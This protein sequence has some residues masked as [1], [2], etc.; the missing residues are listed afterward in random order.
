MKKFFSFV[1]A[2]AIAVSASAAPKAGLT[3]TLCKEQ[4]NAEKVMTKAL[5]APAD[6][7]ATLT[8][9]TFY[10]VGGAFYAYTQSGWVDA[11]SYMPSVEVTV[12]GDQVSIAGLAYY[13]PEGAITG[14]MVDNVI[15]FASGQLVGTDEYGDEYLVGS[16]DGQTLSDIV[17]TY[18]PDAQT[19]VCNMYIIESE[20]DTAMSAYT[21]WA[22]AT[23]SANEPETPEAIIVPEGLQTALYKFDGHD[24]YYDSLIVKFVNVGFDAD[25]VY[26]QGM[27]DVI[28]DGWIKGVKETDGSYTF[29]AV[30]LGLYESLFGDYD[31]Y[32]QATSM[33]YDA[34]LDKFTCASFVTEAEGY[35]MDEFDN[36]TLSH[37]VEVAA[38]PADPAFDQFK[39][40]GA[41]YPYVSYNIPVVGTQG[42]ELNPEKLSY[43]FFVQKG[44]ES[45]PL[46]LTTALYQELEADMT[47]IPYLFSDDYDVYNTHLYLNQDEA[48]VRTW[49]KLGLQT[50]YRGLGEEHKSNIV[51]FDVAA[52]WESVQEGIENTE[53]EVKAVKAIRNGQLII[54]K[55]GVEYN[56]QGV[57][58]K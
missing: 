41:T 1:C 49:S 33:T 28:T 29:E 50:I 44:N 11:T 39:F 46:V 52:Y 43:E 32:S 57:T 24:S 56:A 45:S 42:E 55:N 10:T 58:L 53:V 40:A 47:E 48:E 16:A 23:F 15:T 4:I 18:D 26:I 17:F 2:L 12:N 8:S 38:T 13:F 9:G 25:T 14:T 7:V 27:S 37:I 31:I 22:G 35:A 30:Y 34:A 51:W 19:L 3:K 20:S 36:V 54:I 6:A 21:Y 5:H